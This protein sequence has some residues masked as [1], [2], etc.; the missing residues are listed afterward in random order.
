MF[1]GEYEHQMDVKGRLIVPAK[2]REELSEH[3]VITRGLDRCLFGYTMAEWQAIEQKLKALPITKKDARKF[4]RLFF[5]GAVEVELDKQGRMNI[6]ANL[7]EYAKLSKECVI[8]G[9]SSRIEIWD[10]TEWQIFYDDTEP[11]YAEIA[12][13]LIEIDF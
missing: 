8:V 13:D 10:K 3:F 1:M 4:M 7:R 6:P 5:S 11:H 12:E 2:F 9:V